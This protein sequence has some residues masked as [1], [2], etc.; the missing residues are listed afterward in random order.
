MQKK[1]GGVTNRGGG[2]VGTGTFSLF[3]LNLIFIQ[4]LLIFI[5]K[6]LQ[7]LF[8]ILVKLVWRCVRIKIF[9]KFIF[10]KKVINCES[11]QTIDFVVLNNI[12]LALDFRTNKIVNVQDGIQRS[13]NT[14][15][16]TKDE[17]LETTVRN[18]FR[19]NSTESV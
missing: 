14:G 1:K 16:P 11:L 2:G 12:S 15:L 18:L 8:P 10:W 6:K 13:G 3:H 5:F 4:H 17:T 7:H 19:D 9:N